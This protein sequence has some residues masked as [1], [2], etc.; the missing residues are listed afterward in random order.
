[1][2]KIKDELTSRKL[3]LED[4][5]NLDISKEKALYFSE[6]EKNKDQ[7]EKTRKVLNFSFNIERTN[8]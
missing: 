5:D 3:T 1:M 8:D 2:K 4:I 6:I 7:K